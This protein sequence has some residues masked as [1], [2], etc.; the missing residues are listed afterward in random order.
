MADIVSISNLTLSLL[1]DD[2]IRDPDEATHAARTVKAPWDL[3]R[4]T[5][6]R[7]GEF[8]FSIK[9]AELPS[10][11]VAVPYGYSYSYALP[12]GFIRLLEI[13]D[14]PFDRD[15]YSLEGGKILA[16]T[17]GPLYIR[18]VEDVPEVGRWDSLFVTA[19]AH[20]LAY[21]IAER[22]TA[23]R[24]RKADCWQGYRQA[25]KEAIGADAVEN[26]PVEQEESSW[27]EARYS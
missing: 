15:S 20:R 23:D 13:L 16:D 14:P 21:T 9:R 10:V 2:Q 4:Q 27:V 7:E 1:G 25:I 5:V 19:F 22:I 12:T 3:V 17:A 26:P 11:A 18:Y 8:N 6:L 24:A